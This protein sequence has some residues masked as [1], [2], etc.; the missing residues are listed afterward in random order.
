[1]NRPILCSVFLLL[2]CHSLLA[3]TQIQ[4]IND[5]Q[6]EGPAAPLLMAWDEGYYTNEGLDVSM[7]IG[8]GSLDA[9]PKVDSGEFQIG[10]ADI[11]S[12]VK[13]L[14]QNPDADLKAVFVIYNAPPFAVVSRRSLGVVGPSDLAGHIL[15]APEKD[16]AFAQWDSFVQYSGINAEEV[17]IKDVSFAERETQL[18]QGEVHAITGYSF[19]SVLNLTA[20]GVEQGDISLMLMSDFGLDLYGNVMVVNGEF[21]RNNADDVKAFLRASTKG[22]LNAI[23]NPANAVKHVLN[24]NDTA[25]ESLELRRLVMAI[26]HHIVTDE[27][28]ESGIGACKLERLERSIEQIS[29]SYAFNNR[30][31]AEDIFDSQYLPAREQ[32]ELLK[33]EDVPIAPAQVTEAAQ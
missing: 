2:F 32:R 11:N 26:G 8:R 17:T 22:Y 1:M 31:A 16:G 20:K 33:P 30:P 24:H 10:S 23:A 21:A 7:A 6:W 15:G 5:W 18:A 12:L 14:D 19:S 4:F 25:D 28:R 29:H 13:Y 9:L 27:V 3:A